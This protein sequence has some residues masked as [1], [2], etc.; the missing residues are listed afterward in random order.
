VTATPHPA[1]T[2]VLLRDT[3][4]GLETFMV[5]RPDSSSFLAGA[6]VFA[7]GRVDPHDAD[8]EWAGAARW[9]AGPDALRPGR[10]PMARPALVAA[11]RELFEEAGVLLARHGDDA[12]SAPA[13]TARAATVDGLLG[14]DAAPALAAARSVVHGGSAA[15]LDVCRRSGWRLALDRL[16]PL[17]RW[18][19]PPI[20]PRRFDTR[21]FLAIAPPGQTAAADGV[22]AVA[23]TWVGPADAIAAH[24]DGAITLWPPT[25]RTLEDLAPCPTA[26]VALAWARATPFRVV[27]PR[28]HVEGGRRY[29]L[30]P[31]DALAPVRAE[32]DALPPPTRFVEVKGRWVSEPA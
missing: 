19:T 15:L 28:V 31:G 10:D 23:G 32:R 12:A 27:A 17:C 3:R 26:E 2:I 24:H 13:A 4:N 9:P 14:P 7:G 30:L 8:P 25:L 1:A 18:V 16:L 20:E 11:V 21:F 29:L 6:Q 22:E 5:R